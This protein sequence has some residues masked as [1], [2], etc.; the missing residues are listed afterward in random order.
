MTQS[1]STAL[2]MLDFQAALCRA[3]DGCLAPPLAALVEERGTLKKAGELLTAAREAGAFVVHV[4]IGFDEN[5]E[6]RTNRTARF[7]NF[8]KAGIMKIGSPEGEFMPEVAP[9]P[10]E[11]VVYKGSV[12]P[13]LSTSLRMIL[14]AH[15]IKKVVLAGVST[16]LVVE[17]SARHA[18]DSALDV[19][20]VEDACMSVSEEMHD[21]AVQ[22][23]L[24]TFASVV[25]SDAVTFE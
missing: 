19:V 25:T 18:A 20:V 17:S 16:N 21:F 12:N 15:G 24:P 5:Y 7:D 1:N 13:F 23:T 10:G 2:L 11:P 8:E 3:G 14:A 6:L 4:G 22:H 9:A